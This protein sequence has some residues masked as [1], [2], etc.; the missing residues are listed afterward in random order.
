MKTPFTHP[1]V[2]A[3]LLLTLATSS[4]R[5]A[6]QTSELWGV[7]GEKWQAAGGPL[8]D[9]SYAGYQRGEKPLPSRN[10]D[11]SVKEFGA[12][13]DGKTDDTTAIQK[14]I[15]A[16]PGKTI[17]LPAGRYRLA[18][19]VTIR[20]SGTVLQGEGPDKTIFVVP[21]PLQQIHPLPIS[22][23]DT[24]GTA[25]AYSGGFIAVAGSTDYF[26]TESQ[27]LTAPAER[28][29]V[30][31]QIGAG[32]SFKAG[33][34]VVVIAKDTAGQTL[35]RHLYRDD[36]ADVS[37]AGADK[38][39]R[40]ISRVRSVDG[41]ALTLER[42]LR[43]E[44]RME[45]KPEVRLFKPRMQEVGI[46]HLAFEFPDKPYMG[47]FTEQGSNAISIV[48]AANSWVRDVRI[49]N[50]DS[51]VFLAGSVFST[52]TD[53]VIE[54]KRRASNPLGATGHHGISLTSLDCLCTRFEFRT[55]FIHDLTVSNGSVGNV[56]SNGKAP[57][58]SLDHHKRAPYEN[59]F[60]NLDLGKGERMF[61][62]GGDDG[63]GRNAAAGNTYWNLVTRSTV[64][65]PE[66]FGPERLNFAGVKMR[67]RGKPAADGLWIESIR[68]G[69][70][71]PPDL[72]L[73][74]LQKRLS[75]QASAADPP[76]QSAAKEV[77]SWKSS[78]G[79]VIE[80]LFGGLAG[81]QVTLIREGKSF[82][83]PL[84]RLAPESQAQARK[85]AVP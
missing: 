57:D 26:G 16:N 4:A 15:D 10:P 62:S 85:L 79:R 23:P 9:F 36:A 60:S 73:A 71:T 78:D 58:M 11:A 75:G 29:A 84:S 38:S 70:L 65:M 76:A 19:V 2:L 28:G 41:A 83:I 66:G 12:I 49:L 69:S 17:R 25:Y 7:A 68:P 31:L 1:G 34:E 53:I 56:F 40:H 67:A 74:M 54:S 45:W 81:D 39:F 72:H 21:V 48:G 6:D 27:S 44:L 59:L 55:S 13:G 32:H 5:A 24:E 47:H 42:P 8:P 82:T 63:I 64:E 18:D 35:L 14:A 61:M 30:T 22:Y 37:K 20:A 80:A 43:T 33:D 3:T 77:S 46:E 51:A 50:A 52:V